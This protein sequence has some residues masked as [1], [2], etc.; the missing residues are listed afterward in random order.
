MNETTILLSGDPKA[1]PD[2]LA[3]VEPL[4]QPPFNLPFQVLLDGYT[5]EPWSSGQNNI[6]TKEWQSCYLVSTDGR[7]R[8]PGFMQYLQGRRK[9]ALAKFKA[10]DA[11]KKAVLVIPYDGPPIPTEGLPQGVDK[12]QVIFAKYL[13]DENILLGKGDDDAQKKKQQQML[14]QQ[15]QQKLIEEKKRQSQSQQKAILPQCASSSNKTGG[16]LGNLLGKQRRTDTHLD[17]VRASKTSNDITAFDPTT[18]AAGCINSFRN[19]VSA[20]LE[21]FKADPTTVT[22]KI[23]ISL[24]SLIKTVPTDERDKVTMEVLKFAAYEMVEEVGMDRWIAAKEP[25]DFM[26]ECV[27][28]VYKEGHCPEDVLEDL[29]KGELP[30]EIRGQTRHIVESQSKAIERKGKKQDEELV[31]QS[32]AGE[33]NVVVLNTNKRDRRTL[34]Q[35]QK[36]LEDEG[37]DVKR[38]RFE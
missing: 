31:K 29:N 9:A 15:Q 19:K 12:S 34:E 1:K 36:D 22:T 4:K 6:D 35:I 14:Q 26:D 38:S 13:R 32:I 7:N 8:L 25:T 18:G 16:L 24:G 21:K 5:R 30:D 11:S 33:D 28:N 27:I 20:D 37:E 17:I 23:S 3:T 2:F 10:A